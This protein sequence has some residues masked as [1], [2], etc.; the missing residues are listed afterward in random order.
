MWTGGHDWLGDPKDAALLLTTTP[1]V[2]YH[3]NIPEWEHVDF[4]W[5]LDAPQRV[6][7]E[8]IQLIEKNP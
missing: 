3:K 1:N 2:V 7:K 6:Y 4:L 5:G 8:I